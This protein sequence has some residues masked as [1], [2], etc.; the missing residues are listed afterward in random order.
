MSDKSSEDREDEFFNKL[1]GGRKGALKKRNVFVVQEHKFIARFLKQPT[2]CSHCRDFIWGVG[3]QGFQCQI[4]SLVV[5]KRCHEFVAFRCPGADK[6]NDTDPRTIH[7]FSVH[8]YTS[9]TF[10]DHCGSLLYGIFHQGLQCKA[11]NMNIH[12]KCKENV[13]N[14]C[15]CDA[16]E[17]RGRIELKIYSQYSEHNKVRLICEVKGAKNLCKMDPNGLSDPYCKVK[18]FP[19]NK[20]SSYKRKTKTIKACLNPQWNETLIFDLKNEDKDRRLLIE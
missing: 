20:E 17:K 11:C 13:P 6:V 10:C 12:K 16:V 8:T 19:D 15:G 4:C 3:K 1:I 14:L 18:L 5:H 7:Q 9:P 2:F